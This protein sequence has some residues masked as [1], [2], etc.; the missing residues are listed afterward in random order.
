MS[1]IDEIKNRIAC[2]PKNLIFRDAKVPMKVRD[3]N[4]PKKII[5][6][7]HGRLQQTRM[8]IVDADDPF[9]KP[10]IHFHKYPDH[11]AY[12]RSWKEF[13]E[14]FIN[15]KSDIEFLMEQLEGKQNGT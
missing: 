15:A 14:V 2:L 4:D 11:P 1:R 6:D 13:G 3:P 8:D 12:E 5:D 7:P 10:I 9:L